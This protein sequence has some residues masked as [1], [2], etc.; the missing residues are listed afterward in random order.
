MD[1]FWDIFSNFQAIPKWND[2]SFNSYCWVVILGK[3]HDNKTLD[4]HMFC[5]GSVFL[6][7]YVLEVQ[8]NTEPQSLCVWMSKKTRQIG[9]FP[10]GQKGKWKNNNIETTTIFSICCACFFVAWVPSKQKNGAV[11]PRASRFFSLW[12]LK[13]KNPIH[14]ITGEYCSKPQLLVYLLR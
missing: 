14:G 6:H 1:P 3:Q 8:I 7:R 5:W 13:V 11:E 2:G 10:Q 4:I 12:G 9:S